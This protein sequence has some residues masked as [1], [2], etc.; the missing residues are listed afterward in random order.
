[1]DLV[2]NLYYKLAGKLFHT[3]LTLRIARGLSL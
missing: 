1:M 3:L 2:D